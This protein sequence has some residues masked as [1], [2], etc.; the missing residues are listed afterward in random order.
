MA[1]RFRKHMFTHPGCLAI[2]VLEIYIVIVILRLRGD[3]KS[4]IPKQRETG[5]PYIHNRVMGWSGRSKQMIGA[6]KLEDWYNIQEYK[7]RVIRM[8]RRDVVGTTKNMRIDGEPLSFSVTWHFHVLVTM[9][10]RDEIPLHL[11]KW[12]EIHGRECVGT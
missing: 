7:L 8:S 10:S 6:M 11:D 1:D 5:T 9:G 3:I 2:V 4:N 12:H